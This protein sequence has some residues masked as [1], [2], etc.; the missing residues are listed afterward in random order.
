M[1]KRWIL[2]EPVSL[3]LKK[4][5]GE[6]QPLILQLLIN[7]GLDMQKK[8]DEF[9]QPEYGQDILDP[10]LFPDMEKAVARIYEAVKKK[11]RIYIYGDYDADG[12]TSTVLLA[13]VLQAMGAKYDVYIPHREKEGYGL[14]DKAVKYLIRRKAKL[15]ITVDCGISNVAEIETLKKKGIDVIT[16]D[17][18]TE[19]SQ[20]PNSYAIINPKVKSCNYPYYDLAGVGVAFKLA[21]GIIA[22][23]KNNIFSAGFEKWLLDLVAIGTVTDMMPLVGENRTMLKFGLIVL[24]KTKR[25]GLKLLAE[26]SGVWP[27]TEEELINSENIGFVLGPRLNAAGRM[28]HANLA[29][30]LLITEDLKE[31]HKLVDNLEKSNN[32]RQQV[33]DKII[34]EINSQDDYSKK[35]F[36]LAVGKWPVGVIGL[37]SGK[38]KDKTNRPTVVIGKAGTKLI[39]SGRSIPEFNI[40]EAFVKCADLFSVYGGHAGAAGFTLKNKKALAEFEKRISQLAEDSLG[41]KDLS[42]R[43]DIESELNL[44][45]LDW[46][47]FDQIEQ[48]QPFGMANSKPIFLVKNLVVESL[49]TVGNGNK[50]LK[51]FLRHEK[52]V[53][54]FEAIG[55]GFGELIDKMKGGDRVDVACEINLNQYNGSRKLELKI[56]DLNII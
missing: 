55:F 11:Q 48:F 15:I 33:V 5:F 37:A 45:D 19:P 39:G 18:H 28:D 12:V 56:V 9:L 53:R 38:I 24:N 17:H 47:L 6:I 34:E 21:Q 16:T 42:P 43:L 2:K 1:K 26:K 54:S 32:K 31:A 14:N 13:N 7:R 52:M 40:I 23:D 10:F 30:E 3:A 29:Y 27:V 36:I 50:H 41:G 49:R 22:R 20:L 25:A 51:L 35:N 8:I 46:E 4:Q 44:E